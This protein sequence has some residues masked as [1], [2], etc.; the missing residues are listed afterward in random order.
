MEQTAPVEE[1]MSDSPTGRRSKAV[2]GRFTV[3]IKKRSHPILSGA[4]PSLVPSWWQTPRLSPDR[5]PPQRY[6]RR[7]ERYQCTLDTRHRT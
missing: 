4:Y 6:S 3:G 2:T 7:T 1:L 5:T